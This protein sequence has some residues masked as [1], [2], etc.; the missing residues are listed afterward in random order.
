MSDLCHGID[1]MGCKEISRGVAC[2]CLVP[3]ESE[4]KKTIVDT[5][6][7]IKNDEKK[8]TYFKDPKCFRSYFASEF[9]NCYFWKKRIFHALGRLFFWQFMLM[10]L[11]VQ[12]EH[13]VFPWL[14]NFITRKLRGIQKKHMLNCTNML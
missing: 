4:P 6:A 2:W 9:E 7:W 1:L 12:G 3:S 8:I 5:C 14:Q 13:K 10:W 11:K